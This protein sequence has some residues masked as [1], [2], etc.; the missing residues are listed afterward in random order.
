MN[1]Y[2]KVKNFIL[3]EILFSLSFGQATSKDFEYIFSMCDDKN[4]YFQKILHYLQNNYE[5]ILN[6]INTK[7]TDETKRNEFIF[8]LE[9]LLIFKNE[10][11]FVNYLDKWFNSSN[12]DEIETIQNNIDK[13]MNSLIN[14]NKLNHKMIFYLLLIN[15]LSHGKITEQDMFKKI[16]A[17]KFKEGNINSII[18]KGEELARKFIY[19]NKY[20]IDYFLSRKNNTETEDS[21]LIV[22]FML[23]LFFEECKKPENEQSILKK[24][25]KYFSEFDLSKSIYSTFNQVCSK[26]YQQKIMKIEYYYDFLIQII[27]KS[28]DSQY[29]ILTNFIDCILTLK[30]NANLSKLNI[31]KFALYLKNVISS[32]E[33]EKTENTLI[34]LFHALI[35]INHK[36]RKSIWKTCK[37]MFQTILNSSMTNKKLIF[38]LIFFIKYYKINQKKESLKYMSDRLNII[39][40]HNNMIELLLILIYV[41][42]IRCKIKQGTHI[43]KWLNLIKDSKQNIQKLNEAVKE[44]NNSKYK[45]FFLMIN[46]CNVDNSKTLMSQGNY[47]DK[48]GEME[49]D[50]SYVNRVKI[51]ISDLRKAKDL[52][53]KYKGFKKIAGNYQMLGIVILHTKHMLLDTKTKHVFL[54]NKYNQFWYY[55]NNKEFILN[56]SIN[57]YSENLT[58]IVLYFF[59][60]ENNFTTIQKRW[61]KFN[62]IENVRIFLPWEIKENIIWLEANDIK[63]SYEF[64]INYFKCDFESFDTLCQYIIESRHEPKIKSE[65]ENN[66]LQT[67]ISFYNIEQKKKESNWTKKLLK[68]VKNYK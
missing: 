7:I 25:L 10:K 20:D 41:S 2:K 60:I 56:I 9:K 67:I 29:I 3:E 55:C 65:E 12:N 59:L 40:E 61:E 16:F 64:V 51:T 17:K 62:R 19:K 50:A 43:H 27:N 24:Y 13:Y 46:G 47:N 54:Y 15:R 4:I 11:I 49:L 21:E 26:Y 31:Q 48:K 36:Y 1:R 37:D 58:Y 42:R 14:E 35:I 18:L 53:Y 39:N 33:I 23:F 22:L 28:N 8:E 32:P 38:A 34:N 52:I 6:Y 63:L 57:T 30:E 5:K 44:Y 66:A 45:D 68:L